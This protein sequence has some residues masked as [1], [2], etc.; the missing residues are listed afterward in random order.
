MVSLN[1]FGP[2]EKRKRSLLIISWVA[3]VLALVAAIVF[4][5]EPSMLSAIAA[6]ILLLMMTA[7]Y[8]VERRFSRAL[9]AAL[10]RLET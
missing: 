10:R 6:A 1:E 4:W 3:P 8:L 7:L 9:I 5:N 2:M